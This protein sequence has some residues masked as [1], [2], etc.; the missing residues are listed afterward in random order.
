MVSDGS[1]LGDN[2]ACGDTLAVVL[3]RL[4]HDRDLHNRFQVL[5]AV[6]EVAKVRDDVHHI[7]FHPM[8]ASQA[9]K[10]AC[11][12]DRVGHSLTEVCVRSELLV[13]VDCSQNLVSVAGDCS[14]I[15]AS[16]VACCSPTREQAL[17]AVDCSLIRVLKVAAVAHYKASVVDSRNQLNQ[18]N[19]HQNLA[20]SAVCAGVVACNACLL[21]VPR[22]YHIGRY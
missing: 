6:I 21:Q 11:K 19:H 20:D 7:H 4:D 10:T 15:Q 17:K 14:R 8:A 22:P 9:S 18:C 2:R 3:N 1:L 16:M 13:A 5:V 12:V